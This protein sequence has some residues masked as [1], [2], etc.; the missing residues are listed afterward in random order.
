MLDMLAGN[1]SFRSSIYDGKHCGSQ[2]LPGPQAESSIK[3][4]QIFFWTA[5]AQTL[6]DILD[7]DTAYLLLSLLLYIS[8]SFWQIK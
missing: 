4:F 5:I 8:V 7:K 2:V 3:E 1:S 6:L